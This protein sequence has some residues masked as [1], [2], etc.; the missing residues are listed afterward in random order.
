M[1]GDMVLYM[2]QDTPRGMWPLGKVVDGFPGGDGLVRV[3]DILVKGKTYRHPTYLLV[4]LE[5]KPK[6][7]AK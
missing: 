1:V 5:V 2:A 4:P 3:V 7:P 6:V